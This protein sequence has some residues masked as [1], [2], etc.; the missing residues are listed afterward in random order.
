MI[1]IGLNNDSYPILSDEQLAI[2][3][4]IHGEGFFL[5]IGVLRYY[6]GL[7]ILLD[8]LKNTHIPCLIAGSGPIEQELKK[9]AL[10][11]GLSSV[12]FLG[13]VSDEVKVAL[14]KLCRGVVFP[15]HLR[16]EAFGVT[17][18][19][20]AMYGKP[21]I[22]S[23]IGTGTSYINQNGKTGYV[24]PPATPSALRRAIE[25]LHN[26]PDQAAQMGQAAR[27]RYE[28]E[29]TGALMGKRYAQLYREMLKT[30]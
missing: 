20:G 25:A 3:K 13:Q 17:L 28:Q 5:F 19:E 23:E 10:Q 22:S 12:H 9:K 26:N 14:L 11:S 8:A 15:S 21:L 24:V 4:A 27:L 18:L 29:F 16:S 1:P 30:K 7:H 2:Q 6:K